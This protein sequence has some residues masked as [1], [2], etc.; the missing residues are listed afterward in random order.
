MPNRKIN[1][2]YLYFIRKTLKV[3]GVIRKQQA[4][5]AFASKYRYIWLK[6]K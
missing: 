4:V 1:H 3:Q 5:R 2:I 6:L